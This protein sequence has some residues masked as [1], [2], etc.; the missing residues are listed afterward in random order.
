MIAASRNSGFQAVEDYIRNGRY[1]RD[2]EDRILDKIIF[3]VCPAGQPRPYHE[4]E[5]GSV[6]QHG[7]LVTVEQGATV[8]D[9][10]AAVKGAFVDE[11]TAHVHVPA[12]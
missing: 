2:S 3:W 5:D 7:L 10:V 4:E 9:V 11:G 8:M 6:R 12:L 1:R